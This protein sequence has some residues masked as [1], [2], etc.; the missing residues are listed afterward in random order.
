MAKV[1]GALYPINRPRSDCWPRIGLRARR[2]PPRV[3][4]A[5]WRFL[6][7][8]GSAPRSLIRWSVD[9]K[10]LRY[11]GQPRPSSTT[12]RQGLELG[13]SRMRVLRS[14]HYITWVLCKISNSVCVFYC[15]IPRLTDGFWDVF[16]IRQGMSKYFCKMH[17]QLL[18]KPSDIT[19]LVL[20]VK[21]VSLSWKSFINGLYRKHQLR[22]SSILWFDKYRRSDIQIGEWCITNRVLHKCFACTL[23]FAWYFHGVHQWFTSIV[24]ANVRAFRGFAY[25][26]ISN[27]PNEHKSTMNLSMPWQWYIACSRHFCHL[28]PVYDRHRLHTRCRIRFQEVLNRSKIDKNYISSCQNSTITTHFNVESIWIIKSLNLHLIILLYPWFWFLPAFHLWSRILEII[29]INK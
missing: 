11:T 13:T 5:T 18:Q 15:K 2:S 28:K 9:R 6:Q 20:D 8:D 7:V 16:K 25:N 23:V 22:T 3:R 12:S 27:E 4:I 21:P 26:R 19:C 24:R 17:R 1:F 14:N 29:S 10:K